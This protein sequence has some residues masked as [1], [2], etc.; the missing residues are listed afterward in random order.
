MQQ[1]LM[2]PKAKEKKKRIHHPKSI[3]HSKESK[4]CYLCMLLHGDNRKHSSLQEHH[5]FDG[6]NRI[7]S[8]EYGLKVYLCIPH[9]LNG[10][11]PEA[12]HG[13]MEI[14]RLLHQKGQQAFEEKCGSR[15]QFIETFG[16]NYL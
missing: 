6:P 12:V 16:R 15:K 11:G 13:N 3:L 10:F 8:E 2:F 14:M 7:Y 5:I 4:T 9:H 1:G